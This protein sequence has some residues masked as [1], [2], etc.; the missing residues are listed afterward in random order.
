VGEMVQDKKEQEE[1]RY[2]SIRSV[3]LGFLEVVGGS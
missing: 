2:V 3:F 1:E